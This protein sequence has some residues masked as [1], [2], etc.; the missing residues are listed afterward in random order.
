MDIH[1]Y[2][3]R[4]DSKLGQAGEQFPKMS[5][6]APLTF[7]PF[8]LPSAFPDLVPVPQSDGLSL[9]CKI[10]YSDEFVIAHNYLRAALRADSGRGET[11]ERA[12]RL[13]S[14]CLRLNPANYTTWHYRRK[15]IAA[16]SPPTLTRDETVGSTSIPYK[17]D[18]VS[19]A[20]DLKFADTLG[21]SNPKNYQIWYHRRA[22]LEPTFN[23]A[24]E[25][26]ASI[27]TAAI[28]E[29]GYVAKVLDED[30][31]NY[32]VSLTYAWWSSLLVARLLLPISL[33]A[34]GSIVRASTR[35]SLPPLQRIPFFPSMWFSLHAP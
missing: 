21:G 26:D 25:S 34:C 7:Q 30:A 14:L 1:G 3:S 29:L 19:V 15:I 23:G 35:S 13:T 16:L 12:L 9:V 27:E 32:H 6:S 22:L 17:Y 31:K 33:T 2:Y 11:S 4:A 24:A 5:A 8:D 20:S 18:P 10:S 28:D